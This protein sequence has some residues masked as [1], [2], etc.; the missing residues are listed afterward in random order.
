MYMI[1]MCHVLLLARLMGHY[2]FARGRLSSSSVVVCNAAGVRG[3]LA[4]GR[5]DGR[6]QYGYVNLGRH[7]NI[8][9]VSFDNTQ[10]LIYCEHYLFSVK[11]GL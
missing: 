2:C 4:A 9:S 5:V 8:V 3:R 6:R 10:Y 1:Q 11:Y 7:H